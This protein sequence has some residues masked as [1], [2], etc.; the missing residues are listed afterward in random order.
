MSNPPNAAA[1]T[2]YGKGTLMK[3]MAMH[4]YVLASIVL[5]DL[6]VMEH[7]RN[8]LMNRSVL[9]V[10]ALAHRLRRPPLPLQQKKNPLLSSFIS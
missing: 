5:T 2:M 3:K 7:T 8:F 9:K 1:A 6:I 10:L 4:I